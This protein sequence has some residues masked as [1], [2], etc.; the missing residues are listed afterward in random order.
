MKIYIENINLYSIILN[1]IV[2]HKET[3]VT[4]PYYKV[5]LNI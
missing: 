2:F 3:I 5:T 4:S 1:E